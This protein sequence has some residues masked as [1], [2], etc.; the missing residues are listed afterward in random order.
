MANTVIGIFSNT[1]NAGNAVERLRNMVQAEEISVV[2]PEYKD[3]DVDTSTRKIKNRVD[4]SASKGV[5]IGAAIGGLLGFLAGTTALVIPGIGLATGWLA[6]TLIGAAEGGLLGGIT[7]ALVD[8]G[9][10]TSAADKYQNAVKQG[11]TVVA[12]RLQKDADAAAV[13]DVLEESQAQEIS[14]IDK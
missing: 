8:L 5:G 12:V 2:T 6:A 3:A 4:D 11:N 13:M 7:G 1:S 9:V 14:V 10:D